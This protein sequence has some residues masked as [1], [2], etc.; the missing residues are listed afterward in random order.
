MLKMIILILCILAVI[1]VFVIFESR[2]NSISENRT[3][4]LYE[5]FEK[6]IEILD[7]EIRHIEFILYSDHQ[8]T[9]FPVMERI[10]FLEI[11][12]CQLPLPEGRGL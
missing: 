12:E 4:T 11:I 2:A 5:Y 8:M 10:D 9:G 3:I 7:E 6:E 1:M